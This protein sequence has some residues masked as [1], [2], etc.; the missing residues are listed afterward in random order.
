MHDQQS[1]TNSTAAQFS[2]TSIAAPQHVRKADY[3]SG[4]PVQHFPLISGVREGDTVTPIPSRR[5]CPGTPARIEEKY[6]RSPRMPAT[7]LALLKNPCSDGDDR[8]SL[9]RASCRVT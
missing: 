5:G 4:T 8:S 7:Q 2:R 6:P 9:N 1:R 3:S